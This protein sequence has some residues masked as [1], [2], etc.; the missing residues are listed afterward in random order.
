MFLQANSDVQKDQFPRRMSE[1][2]EERTLDFPPFCR[3]SPCSASEKVSSS[4][5]SPCS[6]IVVVHALQVV[7]VHVPQSCLVPYEIIPCKSL[8]Y[9]IVTAVVV[10]MAS[11]RPKV[12]T[13]GGDDHREKRERREGPQGMLVDGPRTGTR[14]RLKLVSS[15]LLTDTN[16]DCTVPL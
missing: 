14:R 12:S 10:A 11:N 13:F 16:H 8:F 3:W 4:T 7:L 15:F 5:H 2:K 9:Q 1:F 6:A